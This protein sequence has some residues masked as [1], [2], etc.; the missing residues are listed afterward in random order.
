VKWS[1]PET[2]ASSSL[3]TIVSQDSQQSATDSANAGTVLRFPLLSAGFG[4]LTG[5]VGFDFKQA[6]SKAWS[7]NNFFISTVT[8]NQ[9]GAQ[10]NQSQYAASQPET[11][12]NV[13]YFPI[14]AGVDFSES[15]A[16]GAT[17]ASLT[18]AGNCVGG[19]SDFA[20][21]SYS[22]RARA[23]YGKVIAM[24]SR[25]QELAAGCSI[26]A[27][28]NAQ[29]ATGALVNNE[30][31]SLGGINSVRGYYEGDQYGDCGWNGTMELRSPFFESRV[32]EI[33]HSVPAWLRATVFTDFGR[34]FLLEPSGARVS[35]QWLWGA[36][37]GLL[38]NVNNHLDARLT[39]ALPLVSTANTPRN[40]WRVNFS[41]GGQY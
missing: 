25:D 6:G 29:A 24:A 26:F 16:L 28:A 30:Q 19:G 23:V 27:R 39:V 33:S 12:A 14:N 7:T 17:A 2:V 15:D 5:N 18:L 8:T 40:D 9:F 31:F 11:S 37:A 38:A 20:Q 13:V 3:L 22:T 41:I 10:T 35:N 4:R 34:Q 32:A 21:S 1:A 36:G